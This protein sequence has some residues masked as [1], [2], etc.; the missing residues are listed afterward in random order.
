MG[1]PCCLLVADRPGPL[2]AAESF[3]KRTAGAET[4][5]AIG[6]AWLGLEVGWTSRLDTDFMGRYLLAA[7]QKEGIDCSHAVCAAAQTTGFQFKSK[8]LDGSDPEVQ[9]HRRGTAASHRCGDDIDKTWL[10][11]ARHLH[12]TGVSPALSESTLPAARKAMD[13]MRT[14][15]RSVSFDPNL[16]QTLWARVRQVDSRKSC[17]GATNEPANQPIFIKKRLPHREA[18]DWKSLKK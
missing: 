3:H 6:L 15:G 2:E 10:L 9:Y 14:A 4:N 5:A 16:R 17:P 7:M 8:V 1:K 18:L 11:W 13:I 12:A